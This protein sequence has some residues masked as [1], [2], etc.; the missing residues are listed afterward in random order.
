LDT[1]P[2]CSTNGHDPEGPP[3]TVEIVQGQSEQRGS[4]DA[5]Q[6]AT[7]FVVNSFELVRTFVET[8]LCQ[9]R[10]S[11]HVL[12]GHQIDWKAVEEAVS[13]CATI[14]QAVG[15]AVVVADQMSR[16]LVEGLPLEGLPTDPKRDDPFFAF[17]MADVDADFGDESRYRSRVA[18]RVARIV[19]P[20]RTVATLALLMAII[21]A[22]GVAYQALR[23][24]PSASDP[25]T[26]VA[27]VAGGNA[28][29][30]KNAAATS[31][32]TPLAPATTAPAP[33]P[34]SLANAAPLSP[35]KSSGLPPIGRSIRVPDSM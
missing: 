14:E 12:H 30:L 26:R 7:P 23:Q 8:V 18:R 34:P 6:R 35:M 19:R 15:R 32:T 3:S 31:L 33:A 10:S 17:S 11:D 16:G 1:P 2:D 29:L 24:G 13:G 28:A 22:S 25:S 9:G 5:A 21:L 20:R 4:V 27:R